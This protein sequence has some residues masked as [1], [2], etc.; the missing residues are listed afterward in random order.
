MASHLLLYP[1]SFQLTGSLPS[2]VHS[3][4]GPVPLL[5]L[6][7]V[8][9]LL[10]FTVLSYY[11]SPG[12]AQS[13]DRIQSTSVSFCYGL[14]RMSLAILLWFLY[15]APLDTEKGMGE[16]MAGRVREAIEIKTR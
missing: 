2:A 5:I 8:L 12:H 1:N 16:C 13:A 14:F 6:C 9:L 11:P 10:F 15:C 7:W 3:S 4:Y